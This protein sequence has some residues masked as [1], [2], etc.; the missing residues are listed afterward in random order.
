M[1]WIVTGDASGLGS[2]VVKNI[3]AVDDRARIVGIDVVGSYD[4]FNLA[5]GYAGRCLV[6]LS[7][8]DQDWDNVRK[9][10][11]ALLEGKRQIDAIIHCAG[12]N[13]IDW[14]EDA[15][16][17]DMMKMFFLHAVAPAML[18]R[19][20][21]DMMPENA[22]VCVVTSNASHMPMTA[23]FGYNISKAAAHMAVRQMARELKPK[24]GWNIFG[25]APN[26]LSGTGM[27]RDIDAQVCKTR[28]W[29]PE[30]AREYQL[31]GL[32][33]GRETDVDALSR[34]IISLTNPL[35]M[36]AQHLNGC[37]LPYGGPSL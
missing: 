6:D 20:M 32:P 23:S 27:S 8:P 28:G 7:D 37:I 1:N 3:H 2:A 15:D 25:V 22:S 13:K 35:G 36:H 30:E 17:K 26:K 19:S 29:T 10:A 33:S 18:L 5:R 21:G 4:N 9:N 34:M 14:L 12:W 31:K 16:P 11:A 24:R